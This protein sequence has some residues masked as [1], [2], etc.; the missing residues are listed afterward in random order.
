MGIVVA[1]P[2][3]REPRTCPAWCR[4][5]DNGGD[6]CNAPTIELDF[7]TPDRLGGMATG[8]EVL[9]AYDIEGGTCIDV[10]IHGREKQLTLDDADRLA[11]AIKAQVGLARAAA[12]AIV[13]GPRTSTDGEV[14]A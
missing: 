11:D 8:A 3:A 5:H 10:L 9:L 14:P 7:D 4:R 1:A 2:A 13:P 6:I 12:S